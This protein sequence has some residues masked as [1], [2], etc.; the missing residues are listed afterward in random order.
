MFRLAMLCFNHLQVFFERA[1]D[2]ARE[3]DEHFHATKTLRGPLHGVPMSLKDQCM[4]FCLLHHMAPLS[5][6]SCWQ[7]TWLGTTA[8]LALPPGSISLPKTMQR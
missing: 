6:Y 5:T 2:E 1:R 4:S 8:A 7:S 3:L